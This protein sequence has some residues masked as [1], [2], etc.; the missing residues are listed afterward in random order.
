MAQR[1]HI[2]DDEIEPEQAVFLKRHGI[3][4]INGSFLLLGAVFL[5]R[6]RAPRSNSA[7][8]RALLLV[9]VA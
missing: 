8:A 2:H 5:K 4:P 9:L 3:E 7:T 6:P 1:T